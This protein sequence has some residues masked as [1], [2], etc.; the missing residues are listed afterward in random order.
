MQLALR[1]MK[2]PRAAPAIAAAENSLIAVLM[3]DSLQLAGDQIQRDLPGNL[4]ERLLTTQ[5]RPPTGL[6][7]KTAAYRRASDAGR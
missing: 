6:L 1:V 2:T 4:D 7:K 3:P 5:I